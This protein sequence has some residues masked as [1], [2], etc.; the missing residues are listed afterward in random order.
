[1]KTNWLAIL[2]AGLLL[3]SLC[4]LAACT[5]NEQAEGQT[6]SNDPSA[7]ATTAAGTLPPLWTGEDPI[8]LP[9]D[10]FTH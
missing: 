10:V 3:L 4:T 7:Q 6:G 9:D 8:E 1:M 2:I 5:D